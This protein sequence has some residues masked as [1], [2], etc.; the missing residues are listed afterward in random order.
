MKK[1]MTLLVAVVALTSISVPAA[2]HAQTKDGG[3]VSTYYNNGP[4]SGSDLGTADDNIGRRRRAGNGDDND[5]VRPVPEP[6]TMALASMGLIALG[7]A[8][9]RRRNNAE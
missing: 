1:F 6:G 9:R 5:P 8:A 3:E 2:V 7:A 4:R